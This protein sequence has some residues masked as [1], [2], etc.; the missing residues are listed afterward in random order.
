MGIIVGDRR[1]VYNYSNIDIIRY[2]VLASLP[3]KGDVTI[4]ETM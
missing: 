2:L 3:N 1:K 4:E